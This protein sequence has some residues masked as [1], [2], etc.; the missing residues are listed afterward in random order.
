M[1]RKNCQI[2]RESQIR[3]CGD[4]GI[5]GLQSTLIKSL[6]SA[7]PGRQGM[8]KKSSADQL[9]FL[10][11]ADDG[12]RSQSW[13]RL[14]KQAL[15]F[16]Q[17][18][19]WPDVLG[20]RMA[21]WAGRQDEPSINVLSLFSGAGGLDI[22]FHDAGF[23]IVECNELE[24]KFAKTLQLNS[25]AGG[26]LEGA[27]INCG[28][29]RKFSPT[30]KKVDFVIGGPPC[31]TFSAAGARAAGVKGTDDARGMLF[32][33]Y[34]RILEELRP[35]GFL[36]E[37]V[38]R[39]VG[40]QGGAAWARIQEEFKGLGY[41]LYWRILDAADYGVPQHRERL[42]IVGLRNGEYLFPVPS[43]GPDS[44]GGVPYY[45]AATA[46]SGLPKDGVPKKIGGRHGHLLDDIPPGLNYS[47]YTEKLGH[48]SPLFG[49]RSK[50]SDYLYKADPDTPVRTIKAQGG[51]YTGPFSWENRPFS[52]LEI[53]RLQTFPDDYLLNGNR[54]IAVHQ[55]GNSVPPQ[56]ARVLALTIREQVFGRRMPFVVDRLPPIAKLGFRTRRSSLT[57]LYLAKAKIATAFSA[58]Q[59]KKFR[60]IKGEISF[61]IS[62]DFRL[63]INA[64]ACDY[65]A[66]Y[67]L[68]D[69]KWRI[70]LVEATGEGEAQYMI[71]IE[72]GGP[73]FNE[74]QLG[75]PATLV[76]KSKR[77]ESLL[78]IW[79]IYEH[80]LNRF[81]AKDDLIQLIGYYQEKPNCKLGFEISNRSLSRS[82]YWKLAAAITVRNSIGQI[83][84]IDDVSDS[85][86]MER[87]SLMSA[88]VMLK[89]HGFEIRSHNTNPQIPDG[90]ILVPYCFPTLTERSLQRFTRL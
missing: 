16:D 70:E 6:V 60:S 35:T 69:K 75:L 24:P 4:N 61:S 57:D 42:I 88:L 71:T 58:K 62:E 15:G 82:N 5:T 26:R 86:G 66:R 37:N 10:R 89:R 11:G 63:Q 76:S 84:G 28:D 3:Y 59:V 72:R 79:K 32:V 65:R 7:L 73:R 29:I 25:I 87:D 18:G 44:V 8:K 22:G 48:P 27:V 21:D 78:A 50:F 41:T 85:M 46:V 74:S 40:A 56:L 83:Q 77:R 54:Q 43:H 39:I 2:W 45:T 9:D 47:F 20:K 17:G 34:A 81:K 30:A 1:A 51:Q 31:Q 80:L 33:E 14:A 53:K 64:E 55:L 38:Y 67:F 52:I 19:G 36:F 23:R 49:W 12:G 68:D 90:K 13:L